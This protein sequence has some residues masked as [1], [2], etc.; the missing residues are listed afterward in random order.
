MENTTEPARLEQAH[1]ITSSQ[2]GQVTSQ[3]RK[4]I[5]IVSIVAIL[6]L[7]LMI[8]AVV[9]LAQPTTDTARIRDIFII[10]MALTSLLLG[11]ALIILII[12]LARLTNLLQNEI[13]PILA[14]TN[15]T[16]NTLRGT[17]EFLSEN[18]VEPVMKLNEYLAALQQLFGLLNLSRK[19]KNNKSSTTQ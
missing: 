18:L 3:Q 10:F 8:T 11:V 7:A 19:R 9:I 5:I 17:T 4:T 13:K 12:Q 2:D 14:S 16:I 6:A 1:T 15:E